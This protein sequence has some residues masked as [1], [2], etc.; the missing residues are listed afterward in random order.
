MGGNGR[1]KKKKAKLCL[2]VC[3]KVVNC[4]NALFISEKTGF[5]YAYFSNN[6]CLKVLLMFSGTYLAQTSSS[7][8]V[9]SITII[10]TAKTNI[11][12]FLGTESM[13]SS[14]FLW[15]GY[16]ALHRYWPAKTEFSEFYRLL[17]FAFL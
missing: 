16:L 3:D 8:Q 17:L 5:F 12:T 1:Q 15:K 11:I 7:V 10:V 4:V 6:G 9:I 14:A 13:T 2:S